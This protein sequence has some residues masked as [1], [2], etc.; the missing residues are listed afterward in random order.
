MERSSN[1]NIKVGY[2]Y[3]GKDVQH[4]CREFSHPESAKRLSLIE[5]QINNNEHLSDLVFIP[6]SEVIE[7][8]VEL[9]HD[10]KYIDKIK[11]V[12][13]RIRNKNWYLDRGDTYIDKGTFEAAY[14]AASTACAAIQYVTEN[15]L[16]HAFCAIRPPGHHASSKEFGGFCIFNN[17]AIAAQKLVN[18]GKK[19]F[20]LDFDCHYGNGTAEIFYDS[21]KVLYMSVHQFPFYPG[22]GFVDEIGSGDGKGFNIPIPVPAGA[23][24]D[25]YL[26]AVRLFIP[27]IIV[28]GLIPAS[29]AGRFSLT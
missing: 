8:C 19:V 24:D 5:K 12:S 11:S 1:K 16:N 20:I 17:I 2:F 23:G 21:D 15:K 6:Q 27:V 9:A 7:G 3:V 26:Q 28:P 4:E 18:K 14:L 29:A 10:L 22:S 25:V 13:K